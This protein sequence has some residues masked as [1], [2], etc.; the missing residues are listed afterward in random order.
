ME[1]HNLHVECIICN[2]MK[3]ACLRCNRFLYLCYLFA[4]VCPQFGFCCRL[5]VLSEFCAG[6]R[7]SRDNLADPEEYIAH[8]CNC[9]A[10]SFAQGCSAANG[11]SKSLI[12]VGRQ[13][14]PSI[15]RTKSRMSK[16]HAC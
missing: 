7:L 13:S 14:H 10:A 9:V 2:L 1:M 3:Y 6:S 16:L 5:R 11:P 12:L 15:G 8:Q 4:S